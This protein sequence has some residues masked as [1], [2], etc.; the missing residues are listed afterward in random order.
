MRAS[1]ASR[2]GSADAEL[3]R[4]NRECAEREVVRVGPS[5]RRHGMVEKVVRGRRTRLLKAK[6]LW[7]DGSVSYELVAEVRIF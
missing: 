1:G 5:G 4:A 3:E 6:C 7:D 2:P